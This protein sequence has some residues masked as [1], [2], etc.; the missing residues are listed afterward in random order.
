MLRC[1]V[2]TSDGWARSCCQGCYTLVGWES[3]A[4][5]AEET[6]SPKEV[7]PRAMVRAILV[8]GGIGM[9]FLIAITVAIDDITAV[10]ADPAPVARIIHDTLGSGAERATLIIVSIAMFASA[11]QSR[12]AHL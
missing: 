2:T 5:L 3:A 7:V 9:L 1:H 4:N 6:H 10:S 11:R 8:A 12:P